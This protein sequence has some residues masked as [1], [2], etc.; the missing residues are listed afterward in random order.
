M[1]GFDIMFSYE[2][3]KELACEMIEYIE[4]YGIQDMYLCDIAS[5]LYNNDYYIIGIYKA[6]EWLKKYLPELE[7]DQI[8]IMRNGKKKVNYMKTAD[9]I[10]LDDYSKNLQE[11]TDGNLLNQ[12]VK[13]EQDGDIMKVFKMTF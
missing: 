10:L 1:K 4:N 6:K 13:I 11:W 12:A 5:N 7:S 8:I 3:K 9:G 2:I